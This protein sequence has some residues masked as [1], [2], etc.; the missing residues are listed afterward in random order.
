MISSAAFVCLSE[1][2]FFSNFSRFASSSCSFSLLKEGTPLTEVQKLC[3]VHSALF[4]GATKEER[5]ANAEKEVE[6]SRKRIANAEDG[7]DA[8]SVKFTAQIGNKIFCSL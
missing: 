4:H 2:S 8:S 1:Y 5:I 3:D 7:A 6:A